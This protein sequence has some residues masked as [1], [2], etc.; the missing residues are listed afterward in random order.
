MAL[1]GFLINFPGVSPA[2]ATFIFRV[3]VPHNVQMKSLTCITLA[4]L[5]HSVLLGA[6]L[7]HVSSLKG[8]KFAC[9]QE[10]IRE[11]AWSS[12]KR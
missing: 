5:Q 1:M 12:S 4:C 9:V 8:S 2:K 11:Q 6:T 3:F 7:D 10:Y